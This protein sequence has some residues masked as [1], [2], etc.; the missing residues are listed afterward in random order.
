MFAS[1]VTKEIAVGDERVMLRKLSGAQ[2]DE[3]SKVRQFAVAQVTRQMGAELLKAFRE[4]PAVESEQDEAARRQARYLSYDRLTVLKMGIVWWS[5]DE[6]PTAEKIADLDE[7]TMQRLFEE[8]LDLSFQT[9]EEA[10][11]A[12]KNASG[13]STAS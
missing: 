10:A 5:V 1:K 11:A 2:L 3:A 6:K 7:P 8:I 9:P 12:R 13:P 4:T